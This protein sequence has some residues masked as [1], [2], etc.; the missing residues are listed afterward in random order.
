MFK[1]KIILDS[2]NPI[3]IYG[4]KDE[5]INLLKSYFKNIIITVRGLEIFLSGEKKEIQNFKKLFNHLL[6]Y[7]N[8]HNELN[9]RDIEHFLYTK[10][11]VDDINVDFSRIGRNGLVI[12]PRTINLKKMILDQS[13][14]CKIFA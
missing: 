6:D 14:N 5:K 3:D 12:R 4:A 2:I 9:V 8:K 10:Q 13:K 1:D 11:C 7:L